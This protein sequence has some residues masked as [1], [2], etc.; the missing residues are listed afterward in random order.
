MARRCAAQ[1]RRKGDQQ[2]GENVG[3]S[4]CQ[5]LCSTVTL[6]TRT[7]H[8]MDGNST[9]WCREALAICTLH[10][11]VCPQDAIARACHVPMPA[12]PCCAAAMPCRCMVD[13][14]ATLFCVMVCSRCALHLKFW[15][16]QNVR[17][18]CFDT[19]GAF[20]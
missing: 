3:P 12:V 2:N 6:Y 13:T 8:L 14:C 11:V 1:P 7:V 18:P 15:P 20:G 5:S 16:G 19:H 17:H 10:V 4:Q 9:I